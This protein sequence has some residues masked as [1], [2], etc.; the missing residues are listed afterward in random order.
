MTQEDTL[1]QKK[2]KKIKKKKK[3]ERNGTTYI[4]KVPRIRSEVY[5]R[6]NFEIVANRGRI[7]IA[8]F[9]VVG[10]S[11]PALESTRSSVDSSRSVL[12]ICHPLKERERASGGSADARSST[13]RVEQ[14]ELPQYIPCFNVEPDRPKRRVR[15]VQGAPVAHNKALRR[16]HSRLWPCNLLQ[17]R[18]HACHART[19]LSLARAHTRTYIR[20]YVHRPPEPTHVEE[21][22]GSNTSV[23]Y[24]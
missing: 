6:N 1:S 5:V 18:T 4:V 15:L 23:L 10:T 8:A 2:K 16:G 11:G 19:E 12:L 21:P 14:K 20:T 24:D 7:G 9:R 17:P 3:K 13:G 22:C